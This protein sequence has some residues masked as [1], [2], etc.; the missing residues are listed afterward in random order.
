MPTKLQLKGETMEGLQARVLNEYPAGSHIVEA[1]KVHVGGIGGFMSRTHFEAVVEVPDLP[2]RDA[3]RAPDRAIAKPVRTKS[4]SHPVPPR[5]GVAALLAEANSAE[6]VLHG[7]IAIPAM[8]EVSTKTKSFD[9]LM[10]S[11]D[12]STLPVPG[13]EGSLPA[14]PVPASLPGDAVLVIGIGADALI[15]AR[16]MAAAT[17]SASIKTAG[18]F[19]V[20]GTEHLVGRQGLVT[21]RASAVIAGEPVFIAF[22]LGSDGSLRANALTEMKSDQVWLVVDATRKPSDTDA[23]VRKVNWAATVT[24]L[25]VIGSQDTL[26]PASVNDYDLPIGWLDGRKAPRSAL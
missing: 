10:D 9:D 3:V 15:T 19:R 4:T 20:E 5:T 26:S 22:G 25:A 6:D 2:G 21:A 12:S 13:Q 11:L 18:S 7:V 14:V 1:E 23:W 17:G 8:P 24:A 16:S